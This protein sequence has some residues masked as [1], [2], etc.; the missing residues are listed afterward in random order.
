M[1]LVL[2]PVAVKAPFSL[3]MTCANGS[4]YIN[5]KEGSKKWLQSSIVKHWF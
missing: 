2:R 4:S 1:H 5:I 3:C